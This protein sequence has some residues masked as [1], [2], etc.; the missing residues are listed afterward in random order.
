K[1]GDLI[2]KLDETQVKGM[3]LNDAVKVMR[4]KPG[5]P[6]VLTVLRKGEGKA[7]TFKIVRDIIKTKSVKSKLAEPG[8]AYV[9]ITQFQEHTGEDLAKALKALRAENKEPFKGLVLDLRNNPGGLLNAAVGVSAAFLPRN[10]L[11]VYTDGRTGDAKMRLSA[12][13]EDYLRGGNGDDY[14]RNLPAELK[15]VP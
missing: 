5:T 8:Y 14:L 15:T 6:I 1:S 4:G 10:E 2:I 3:S 11:V 13:P 7:L 9:R 12:T